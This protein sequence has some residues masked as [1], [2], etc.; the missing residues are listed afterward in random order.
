MFYQILFEAN[1]SISHV[2]SFLP[3][4]PTA[5]HPSL[6]PPTHLLSVGEKKERKKTYP[7]NFVLNVLYKKT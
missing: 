5:R 4:L 2:A 6:P 7:T 1:A 3:L